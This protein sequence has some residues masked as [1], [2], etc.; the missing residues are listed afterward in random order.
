MFTSQQYLKIQTWILTGIKVVEDNL[1]TK[2]ALRDR[3]LI[4]EKT[5]VEGLTYDDVLIIPKYSNINSR[6]LVDIFTYL[7]PKIKL[8]I[9]MVSGNMDCV[10]ESRMAIAMARIG[11]IGIVHRYLSIKDQVNEILKVKRAE[12]IIIDK[13]YTLTPEHNL[14]DARTLMNENNIKGILVTDEVG[15][16]KGILT[17]R[18][19]MFEN[20]TLKLIE[21]VMTKKNDAITAEFGIEIEKAKI[22][23]KENK[24]EKLPLLDKNGILKGLITSKDLQRKEQY[25]HAVKDKRGRLL[26][27][28]AIGVK[29]DYIERAEALIES[30][31]DVI[32]ID[33]AHGHSELAIN[34][35]KAV[36]DRF[37]DV[38][39][40]AGNVVTEEATYDLINVG[41]DCIKI[42]IGAGSICVTRLVA[43]SGYPQFSA[44]MNCAR[45]GN[46]VGIPVMADGGIG[47]SPGNFSKAIA[48]GASTVM[49][50]RSLAGT[51]ESPGLTIM[52]DGKKYKIYRGSASFGGN[53]VRNQRNNEQIDTE[54]DA[55]GVEALV[56]YSG[57]VEEVI[58]PFLAGLRSGMS[59]AGAHNLKEFWE[60][61]EFVKLTLSGIKESYPHHVDLVK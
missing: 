22:I 58:K 34:A 48:A 42:G 57:N 14:K 55:E 11:G 50:S 44:V 2:E 51:D 9:P 56:P 13:P 28:A 25:P 12:A 1:I 7:T 18:D 4:A 10:T 24:I 16:F 47:G 35:I 60:K 32:C 40:I 49:R 21:E 33:I 54:Y 46:E 31:C 37:N 17:N 45:V 29:G 39:L 53:M 5:I 8:S 15:R 26:V 41:A 59:Y 20:N 43:G 3:V 38:Q 30:G 19:L 36:K 27:G 23:M 52:R 6:K 61:A